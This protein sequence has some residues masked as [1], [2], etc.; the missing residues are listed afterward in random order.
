MDETPWSLLGRLSV[1]NLRR[2]ARVLQVLS[3]A[4]PH[5][6]DACDLFRWGSGGGDNASWVFAADGRILLLV[7]D[8]ESELNLFSDYEVGAQTAM[9]NGIPDDLLVHVRGLP[10]REPFLM[11]GDGADAV[12]AASGV[13][14]F[15]GV[16]W[17]PAD[18]LSTLVSERGLNLVRDSGIAHCTSWYLLD[19]EFTPESLIAAGAEDQ[20]GMN[21]HE[22]TTIFAAERP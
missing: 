16:A 11:V 10:D 6:L 22:V 12:P 17:H 9:Y 2:R 8:H 5:S 21:L 3:E 7:F 14:W 15:D 13:F 1:E 20:F 4:E 19:Q 18:G